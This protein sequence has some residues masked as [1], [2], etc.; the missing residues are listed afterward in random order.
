MFEKLASST[1]VN[2]Q[3]ET[4]ARNIFQIVCDLY[5][6]QSEFV[7]DYQALKTLHRYIKVIDLK[8]SYPD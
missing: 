4:L 8:Q 6:Q 3:K 7:V 5:V 1:V 2:K